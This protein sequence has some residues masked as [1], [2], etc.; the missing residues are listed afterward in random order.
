MRSDPLHTFQIS[1]G[2][3]IDYVM[4]VCKPSISFYNQNKTQGII[5]MKHFYENFRQTPTID[6]VQL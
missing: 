5:F 3:I 6:C 1:S 4:L 2:I